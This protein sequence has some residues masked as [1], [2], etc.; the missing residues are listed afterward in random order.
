MEI[1]RNDLVLERAYQWEKQRP[2]EIY[3][4][5]PTGRGGVRDYTW[6]TTMDEAR[7]MAAYLQSFGFPPGSKI[8]IVSKNCAHFIMAE[9]AIWMAGYASVA[10]YP[11]LQP[12]TVRYILEH[13]ESKLLFVGKLDA[14]DAMKPGMPESVHCISYPLSPPTSFETWDSIV[15][16]NAPL[17]TTDG[18]GIRVDENALNGPALEAI[19]D[20]LSIL[21]D[22][23]CLSIFSIISLEK[24]YS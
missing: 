13:S 11:T 22:K 5:Q 17:E 24:F 7:R 4:T 20:A 8:A 12:E 1:E 23:S 15:A 19:E 14:W 21:R 6:A 2:D 16:A 9:L 10:L 3:M 18:I